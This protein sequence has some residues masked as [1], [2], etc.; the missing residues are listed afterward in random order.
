MVAISNW[1]P[2]AVSIQSSVINTE[3]SCVWDH[4][5]ADIVEKLSKGSCVNLQTRGEGF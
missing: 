3:P 1:S 2:K 5:K 4:M